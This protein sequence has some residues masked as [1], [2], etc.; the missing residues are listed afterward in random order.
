MSDDVILR[1]KNPCGEVEFF[2]TETGNIGLTVELTIP[3]RRI[4]PTGDFYL[5]KEDI[6]KLREVDQPLLVHCDGCGRDIMNIDGCPNCGT[7][8]YLTHDRNQ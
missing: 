7:T 6:E 3:G 2:R 5:T 1:K 8:R 4:G